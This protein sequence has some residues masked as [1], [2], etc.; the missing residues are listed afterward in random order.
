MLSNVAQY[1]SIK[2]IPKYKNAFSVHK[3]V[4][5]WTY[6]LKDEIVITLPEDKSRISRIVNVFYPKHLVQGEKFLLFYFCFSNFFFW[7]I[8]KIL[9]ISILFQKCKLYLV[10]S[11]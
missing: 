8:Y 3:N 9:K 11:L 6:K 7:Y 1:F 10:I 4:T 2:L 5:L